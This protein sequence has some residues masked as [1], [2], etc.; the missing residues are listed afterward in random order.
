MGTEQNHVHLGFRKRKID[1]VA[2]TGVKKRKKHS[3]QMDCGRWR[4]GVVQGDDS[5]KKTRREVH[6]YRL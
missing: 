4:E 1:R 5:T 2:G 6:E 3:S